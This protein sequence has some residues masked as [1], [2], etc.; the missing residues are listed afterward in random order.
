M[1]NGSINSS[2]VRCV[3]R[4]TAWTRHDP[5][6]LLVTEDDKIWIGYG[7]CPDRFSHV[8]NV[9]DRGTAGRKRDQILIAA[10]S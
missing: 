1:D 9:G 6:R 4:A 10:N 5:I 7:H 2:R 8:G 3:Y